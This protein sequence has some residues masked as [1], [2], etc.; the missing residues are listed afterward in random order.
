LGKKK[1]MT[2]EQIDR[3]V[4]AIS[5]L[6]RGNNLWAL[7]VMLFVVPIAS[8]AAAY[9][10]SYLR[11]KGE[12]LA[13]KEDLQEITTTVESI[14]SVF[15]TNKELRLAALDRRLAAHQ[16]AYALWK[17]LVS[18]SNK[19]DD[20]GA[21]VEHVMKCQNWWNHN[22]LYLDAEAREAF[23]VSYLAAHSRPDLLASGDPESMK[24]N[25]EIVV[26]AGKKL[27][28]GAALPPLSTDEESKQIEED[29]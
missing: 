16:E 18:V 1:Q 28:A 2:T 12:N 15:E 29:R 6:D 13:T 14:R 3:I 8:G 21:C 5:S 27:V 23:R 24:S 9:Y 11:K 19:R 20:Q 26:A 7:V 17:E 22:C 4:D 25:F 10:G